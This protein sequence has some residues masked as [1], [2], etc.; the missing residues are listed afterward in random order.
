[1]WEYSNE[2]ADKVPGS[3]EGYI[4]LGEEK[5]KND[6]IKSCNKYFEEKNVS[7]MRARREMVQGDFQTVG[8]KSQKKGL[9]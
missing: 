5:Q 9:G 4:L 8:Q 2:Q 7:V 1:M 6:R 3:Y